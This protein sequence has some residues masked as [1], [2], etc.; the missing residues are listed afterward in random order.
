MKSSGNSASGSVMID[1]N[2][3]RLLPLPHDVAVER[4]EDALVSELKGFVQDLHVFAALHLSGV[5]T[6]LS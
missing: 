6:V 1:E 3:G 2:R 5:S 4:V